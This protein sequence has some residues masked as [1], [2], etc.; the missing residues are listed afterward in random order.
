MTRRRSP[1]INSPCTLIAGPRARLCTAP[2]TFQEWFATTTEVT[3]AGRHQLA[4]ADGTGSTGSQAIVSKLFHG[5][6]SK[7]L[8]RSD[9]GRNKLEPAPD[10]HPF[11]VSNE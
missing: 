5:G 9:G 6:V 11:R 10:S 3:N 4:A 7:C 2:R 1:K 8:T